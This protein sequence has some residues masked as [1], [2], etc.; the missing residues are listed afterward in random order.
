MLI[1]IYKI[2]SYFSTR[3]IEVISVSIIITFKTKWYAP[4]QGEG[5]RTRNESRLSIHVR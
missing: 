5:H 4:Q 1:M 2:Y 3:N